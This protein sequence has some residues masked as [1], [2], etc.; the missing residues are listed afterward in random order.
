MTTKPQTKMKSLNGIICLR[1]WKEMGNE[2]PLNKQI[3][4]KVENLKN[5]G[6]IGC[7]SPRECVKC[8]KESIN[9]VSP[10]RD[11]KD[12]RICFNCYLDE[13]FKEFLE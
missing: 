4:T 7:F 8:N 10:S 13:Q 6:V 9:F 1:C 5:T 12:D 2:D 3:K 11:E